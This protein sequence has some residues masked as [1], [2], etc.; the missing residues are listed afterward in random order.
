M[1]ELRVS[2]EHTFPDDGTKLVIHSNWVSNT[3]AT[4]AYLE[5]LIARVGQMD[6]APHCVFEKRQAVPSRSLPPDLGTFT[7]AEFWQLAELLHLQATPSLAAARLV[8]VEGMRPAKAA[9]QLNTSPQA[10]TNTLRKIR[11]ERATSSRLG[12]LPADRPPSEGTAPQ[13]P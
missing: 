4:Q 8:L 1:T 12:R 13:E 3:P 7:S 10:L 11:T 5:A 6:P 2:W 9:R